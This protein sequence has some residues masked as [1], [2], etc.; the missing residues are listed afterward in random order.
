MTQAHGEGV[1]AVVALVF[2]EEISVYRAVQGVVGEA[3]DAALL[4]ELQ[5]QKD[6][7]RQLL[8]EGDAPV[9]VAW[10]R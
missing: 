5:F 4:D 1:V 8:L 7:L 10:R 2:E 6:G 3:V 9:Q